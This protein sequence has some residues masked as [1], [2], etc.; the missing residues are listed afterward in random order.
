MPPPLP[1]G[2]ASI[3]RFFAPKVATQDDSA[4]QQKEE[5]N[6]VVV[7]LDTDDDDDGSDADGDNKDEDDEVVVVEAPKTAVVVE[8]SPIQPHDSKPVCGDENGS[9]NDKQSP[10]RLRAVHSKSNDAVPGAVSMEDYDDDNDKATNDTLQSL[11]T[12]DKGTHTGNDMVQATPAAAASSSSFATNR[13]AQFAAPANKDATSSSSCSFHKR[14]SSNMDLSR[15]V[16]PAKKKPCPQPPL[17]SSNKNGGSNNQKNNWVRMADLSVA[18]QE[19]IV[20]KWH[21]MVVDNTNSNTTEDRRF[22]ILVAARL[23]ARCQ[24]GPVRQAMQNLHAKLCPAHGPKLSVKLLAQTD[25][26]LWMESINNLQYYPTKARHVQKAATII[27]EQFR[28]LVPEKEAD[29]QKL[30]GIGPVLADLLAFVNTRQVHFD[31]QLQK[32]GQH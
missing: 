16:A 15:W 10:Q 28:G 19:R 23:H 7:Q 11:D 21:S 22:Q 20:Q 9:T 5:A 2:Q 18:E 1:T 17:R 30:T 8:T 26:E 13:F 4:R 14:K 24:E 25:P 6:N 32:N 29:L 12:Q 27:M 31:R 3:S